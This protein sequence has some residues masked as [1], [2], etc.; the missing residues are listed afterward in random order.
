MSTEMCDRKVKTKPQ[1]LLFLPLQGFYPCSYKVQGPNVDRNGQRQF[2]SLWDCSSPDSSN[3]HKEILVSQPPKKSK[4]SPSLYANVLEI[5]G[6]LLQS[7]IEKNIICRVYCKS[8]DT[9]V[10]VQPSSKLHNIKRHLAS[11]THLV[12]V[13][14]NASGKNGACEPKLLRSERF[15][16]EFL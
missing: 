9:D 10:K 16:L 14:K 3:E 6:G 13:N 7:A 15:T 5:G 1:K 11:A 8:C 4:R 12:M 2:W